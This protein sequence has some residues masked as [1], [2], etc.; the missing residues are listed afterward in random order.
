[1]E[2]YIPRN[3][4][5]EIIQLIQN[6]P[7]VAILGPRQCGKSTLARNILINY[8]TAI[9]LDLENPEDRQKLAAPELFFS[10][11]ENR[12]ICLDEI[13]RIP[14]LFPL[15][16]SVIDRNERNGQFLILG[17]AS[18]DLLRQSSESLAGRIIFVELFPFQLSELRMADY[19][20]YWLKGGFPRSY[21]ASDHALSFKWRQSFISTF[22]ERDLRQL[23]FNIPPESMHRLWTMCAN[24]QGQLVN[25]SQI[26]GSLGVSHT[27]VRTYIDLL[28]ETFMIRVLQPLEANLNKRLVKS[29]KIY[30]RDTGILHT[31]LSIRSKEDL[32]GHYILG[33]SWESLVIEN[34]LNCIPDQ[35]AGF[36]RTA[37]GAEI[38]LVF[39]SGK[40]KIAVEC[41]ASAVP[42]PDRGFY[43]ALEDLDISE[44]WVIAPVSI[45][46]PLKEN[47]F[48]MSLAEAINELK[49][50]QQALNLGM[51]E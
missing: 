31:L 45:R 30:L 6:F 42:K 4:E 44:S 8:P 28:K 35:T 49:N 33:A 29:P 16:R 3:Q 11:H 51:P 32:L 24:R 19:W 39:Q 47:V 25:L 50:L 37:G 41:K 17:S 21:L 26:G 34:I 5:D 43:Q 18:R 20:D 12:L 22:L 27:T 15:L 10:G 2:N 46:Y 48:V 14:E 1:M 13:Q 7:A 9:F 38:D 40:R 23:G 36:Y